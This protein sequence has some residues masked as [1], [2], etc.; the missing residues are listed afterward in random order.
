MCVDASPVESPP[1]R[2]LY[3]R[4]QLDH[5]VIGT[6]Y[7]IVSLLY[8]RIMSHICLLYIDR[9]C[10]CVR[11]S[12]VRRQVP[13]KLL[14]AVSCRPNDAIPTPNWRCGA[15]LNSSSSVKAT[16]SLCWSRKSTFKMQMNF[17]KTITVFYMFCDF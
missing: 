8:Y 16:S 6:K 14:H 9:D 17:F 1:P 4:G 5:R 11:G 2:A 10:A 15:H 13:P 3:V 7:L 12:F